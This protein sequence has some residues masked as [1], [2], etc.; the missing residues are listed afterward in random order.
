MNDLKRKKNLSERS[1]KKP[2]YELIVESCSIE[3]DS[4]GTSRISTLHPVFIIELNKFL[5]RTYHLV[6]SR[7]H[8]PLLRTS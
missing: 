6:C 4:L 3:T 2:S 7:F 5:A 8:L 1:K